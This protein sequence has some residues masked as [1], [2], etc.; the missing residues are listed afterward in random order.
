MKRLFTTFFC[1]VASFAFMSSSLFGQTSQRSDKAGI[2][3]PDGWKPRP[4]PVPFLKVKQ[5]IPMGKPLA[6]DPER[7]GYFSPD[8]ID[9]D[10]NIVSGQYS[11]FAL[12]DTSESNRGDASDGTYIRNQYMERFTAADVG[13]YLDSVLVAFFADT[14]VSRL[15]CW[16]IQDTTNVNGFPGP[17][18]FRPLAVSTILKSAV[19]GKD[20]QGNDSLTVYTVPFKHLLVQTNDVSPNG[21]HVSLSTSPTTSTTGGAPFFGNPTASTK[22]RIH[23]LTDRVIDNSGRAA[24]PELDRFYYGNTRIDGQYAGWGNMARNFYDVAGTTEGDTAWLYPN[25]FMIAYVSY[26]SSGVN[27]TKLEGNALAQNYPNPFN[28]STEIRYSLTNESKVS[29]KVYNALGSEVATLVDRSE[30]AG[31]HNVNFNADNL[32]SGTYF[33]TLKAGMFSQTKRMVLSK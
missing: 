14:V 16:V 27:D 31:E 20:D 24:D 5:F 25:A 1:I 32:P 26:N 18:L 13:F 11:S 23:I 22:S 19:R 30:S 17:H 9:A 4:A 29:L 28:P 21:F 6:H 10:G 7:L 15:T 3:R 8:M 12:P 33:Y 2:L